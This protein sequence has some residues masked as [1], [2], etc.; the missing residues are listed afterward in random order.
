[1]SDT[2][3]S[4][5]PAETLRKLYTTMLT[6]RLFEEKVAGIYREQE[7]KCPVHLCTGQEAIAAGVCI[8]LN[9]DDYVFSTHRSHGHCIA[10]GMDLKRIAAELYGKATGCSKGRGGSMH[11]VDPDHGILGSTAIVGG[12]MPLAAGAALSARMKGDG[13]ISVA[14]F[15][16]GAVDQGTFHETL[17]FSS[18]K[19]LP[20]IF[21][22]ENNYY[23]TN[24]PQKA[25]QPDVG[26]YER[27]SGYRMPARCVD[28]NDVLM[29][30]EA[31]REAVERARK[32]EGPTL[33]E[34]RTYRWKAHVGPE[35]DVE[36][37]CRP[38]EEYDR[39]LGRCPLEIYTRYLT[40][41]G[42]ISDEETATMI[43]GV[44]ESVNYA[45][46]FAEE[47]PLPEPSGLNEYVY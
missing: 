23:A 11:L 32:G 16:D 37:G 2:K 45:I 28:G 40:D 35:A 44:A 21:V 9:R 31:A 19:R 14:F 34:F 20:V 17:N 12:C 13:K 7:I 25:R 43:A 29:V 18:L 47:S 5:I 36:T 22:C 3:I 30:Y 38:V 27:A 33:L 46:R 6:I 41:A 4:S 26:I 42:I 10:K 39:W 24:S 8:H 15:G 1:M